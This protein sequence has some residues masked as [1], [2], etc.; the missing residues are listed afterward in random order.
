[1]AKDETTAFVISASIIE[2]EHSVYILIKSILRALK[3]IELI[4]FLP[5]QVELQ[6]S[7]CG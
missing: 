6:L 1:M 7:A 2:I 4:P 5:F 3:Q